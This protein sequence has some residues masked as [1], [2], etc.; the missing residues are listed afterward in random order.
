MSQG[1]GIF[2]TRKIEDIDPKQHCVVQRYL[3]KPYLIDGLKFDLRIYVLVTSVDPIQVYI[4]KEGL[5]RFATE[6]YIVPHKDNMEDICMHLTNYAINKD[7][8]KFVFNSDENDMSIGHKRSLTS[9]YA[10]LEKNGMD[11]AV[12]RDKIHQIIIKTLISGLSHLRF[13]YRSSQSENYRSDM[14]F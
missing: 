9:A 12:L 4:Y 1:K 14:C 13:Q 2:L 3:S 8:D 11:V 5:A 6:Q 10:T 7:S